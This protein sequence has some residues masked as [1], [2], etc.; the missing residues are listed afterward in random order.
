MKND[1]NTKAEVIR[2]DRGR[3]NF[4]YYYAWGNNPKRE[5]MKNKRC[6]V[7]VR[8]KMNSVLV[9]FDNGQTEVISRNALRK[10]K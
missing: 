3:M 5:T 7:L 4:E 2:Q 8:G 1:M 10:D 6:R 9:E